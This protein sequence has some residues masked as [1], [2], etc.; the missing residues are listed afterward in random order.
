MEYKFTTDNFEAEV[1]K[2]D[3]PVLVDFYADWCNPCNMMGR[4]VA[5]IAAEYVGKIKVVMCNIDENMDLAKNC[6][7]SSIPA[8][9]IFKGGK[10]AANFVGAMPAAE[11]K[12]KVE[13][14]LG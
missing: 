4:V 6:R 3:I 14:A 11:L 10:P 7:V 9:I 1:L 8:F 12:Q 13:Q 2:S 5:K